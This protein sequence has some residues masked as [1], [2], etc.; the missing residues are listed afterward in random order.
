MNEDLKPIYDFEADWIRCDNKN[1]NV[2]IFENKNL[3]SLFR[4][5]NMREQTITFSDVER[6]SRIKDIDKVLTKTDDEEKNKERFQPLVNMI[7]DELKPISMP[8]APEKLTCFIENFPGFDGGF[9]DTLGILYFRE[10]KEN[11]N[12]IEAKRF[13]KINPE[14]VFPKYDEISRE[15]YDDVKVKWFKKCEKGDE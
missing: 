3:E 5:I 14:G 8:Y 11:G 2:I 1:N 12:M 4:V 10:E 7:I 6:V 9:D 15:M 13:F